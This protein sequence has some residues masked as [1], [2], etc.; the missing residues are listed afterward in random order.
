LTNRRRFRAPTP[1]DGP[2][3][4]RATARVARAAHSHILKAWVEAIAMVESGPIST[5][6]WRHGLFSLLTR[7]RWGE[8]WLGGLA[9]F[10]PHGDGLSGKPLPGRDAL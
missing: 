4:P 3:C 9:C 5:K 1:I 2:S 10:G 6:S 8:Q 7:C